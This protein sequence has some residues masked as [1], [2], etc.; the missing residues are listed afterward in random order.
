MDKKKIQ[1]VVAAAASVILAA[2]AWAQDAFLLP[3]AGVL[4]NTAPSDRF[5]VPVMLP[6]GATSAS[7]IVTGN[8]YRREYAEIGDGMF[9][10]SLP[11]ADS[12]GAENIYDL[13]L[14]FDDEAATVRRARLAVCQGAAYGGSAQADVRTAGTTAWRKIS[15]KALLPVWEGVDAVSVDGVPADESLWT[16]PGY[17]QLFVKAG[18]TYGLALESGGAAVAE[19]TVKGSLDSLIIIVR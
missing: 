9:P 4:W 3:V 17:F 7:L 2:G 8:G 11:P 19:A 13:E 18:T 14:V 15:Q 1:L 10:L 6:R 5:E 12:P 16:S